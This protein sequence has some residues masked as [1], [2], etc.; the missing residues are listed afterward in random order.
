MIWYPTVKSFLFYLGKIK[1]YQIHQKS[2]I[3]A[4]QQ[5]QVLQSLQNPSSHLYTCKVNKYIMSIFVMCAL[6]W[7]K[8]VSIRLQ[9]IA[10]SFGLDTNQSAVNWKD[11]ASVI[12]NM[13]I[14]HSF[15]V[16]T[17]VS[18][19]F[20]T[21]L[22]HHVLR[23]PSGGHFALKCSLKAFSWFFALFKWRN[24]NSMAAWVVSDVCDRMSV[25][26]A[27]GRVANPI[28]GVF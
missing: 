15:K 7:K 8:M 23:W 14:I 4:N 24:L 6:R 9:V 26:L 19:F 13:A 3:T 1:S 2:W 11:L 21:I 18:F 17:S 10:E 5:K 25:L 12:L 22:I 16:S 20:Y 28:R 27:K